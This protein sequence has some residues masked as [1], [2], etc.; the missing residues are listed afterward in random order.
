MESQPVGQLEER[1]ITVNRLRIYTLAA[2][3]AASVSA[4]PLILVPGLNVSSRHTA[5]LGEQ[6]APYM[7]IY[8]LDL[9]GYGRSDKPRRL[10]T[11]AELSDVLVNW[12]QAIGLERAALY[13]SS[14]SA[15]IVADF[16]VRYPTRITRAVLASPT[17]DPYSRPLPKLVLLWRINEHREPPFVGAATQRDYQ[18]VSR[19][20]AFFTL[21]QMV[22]DHIEERLPRMQAPT[23]VVRGSRDPIIS[24]RWAEEACQ[25]LPRGRLVLVPG[26]AHAIDLDAPEKLARVMRPF[27]CEQ[28]AERAAGQAS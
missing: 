27:L 11:L 14:F 12:M 15:Q 25:M 6:L 3:H 28:A 2:E 13:G 7:P 19:L 26:A 9:P 22:R 21:W 8:T 24:Q 1:W 18:D 5:K 4:T 20:R 23:L 17:V 16:A 10:L